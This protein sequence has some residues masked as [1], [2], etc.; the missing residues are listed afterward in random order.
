MDY[1]LSTLG[2]R[3]K[4]FTQIVTDKE[5]RAR[6]LFGEDIETSDRSPLGLYIQTTSWEESKLWD[7]MENVYFSAFI[8][9]AEGKQLDALVKYIGLY[10]KPALQSIGY[11][12]IIGR[13][14]KII[15]QGLRGRTERGVQFETTR[16]VTILDGR[17]IAP[18]RAII[19][20]RTGN[21]TSNSI[22]RLVNPQ[23]GI[24]SVNNIERTSGGLEIES[25][26]ELRDRYYRSLSRKGKATRA[27]IEAALL[28]LPTV[29]DALVL[30]NVSMQTD[31]NGIPPK[32]IAPFIFDGDAMEV[33]QSI[34]D[35]KSAGIQSY[36]N[37][38][39]HVNDSR[40]YPQQIGFTRA[41]AIDVYVSIT[42]IRNNMFRPGYEEQI[43]SNAL[44]YIGGLAQDGTE[45]RGLGLGQ[46]II[47]SRIV[48]LTADSGIDDAIVK[49]SIDNENWSESNID[50][51]ITQIAITD[52]EKVVV[53]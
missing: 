14:G 18:I 40:G 4:P 7:E 3:R 1:G 33:A 13:E 43:K 51:P 26:E 21:V 36:G 52:Y 34:L 5:E 6:D 19:A 41:T 27:A 30:E 46:T 42:L 9:D 47:H 12:E 28:E 23:Q 17:A 2:F 10:R 20:G 35:T 38:I 29:K 16:D 8:D 25:D 45:Y 22:N 53:R 39:I 48:A 32:S 15:P 24:T 50:I 49:I 11:L 44:R 37:I 31:P